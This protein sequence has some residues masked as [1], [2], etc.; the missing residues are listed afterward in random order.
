M[1]VTVPRCST[2]LCH[3]EHTTMDCAR[4]LPPQK[5][6]KCFALFLY[7]SE[8]LAEHMVSRG[9]VTMGFHENEVV[10]QP[11]MRSYHVDVNVYRRWHFAQTSSVQGK[12]G[13]A[14]ASG[15]T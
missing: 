7:V 8:K 6:V 4:R 5:L 12:G 1:K 13:G 10:A 15:G 9:V 3:I 2:H 11:S 14:V